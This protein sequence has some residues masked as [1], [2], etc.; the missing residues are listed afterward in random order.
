MKAGNLSNLRKGRSSVPDALYFVTMI[1]KDRKPGLLRETILRTML[2]SIAQLEKERACTSIMWTMMPDHIHG[3]FRLGESAQPGDVVRVVKGPM[4]PE[5]RALNLAWQKN[6][7]EHRIRPWE[8]TARY[9][10]YVLANPYRK[11]LLPLDQEWDYLYINSA[12]LGWFLDST[13]NRKPFPEWLNIENP[14]P[15]KPGSK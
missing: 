9:L 13:N 2:N 14:T 6:F 15:Q 1:T 3:I 7:H 8:S 4:C 10:R 5:L 11:H 12:E